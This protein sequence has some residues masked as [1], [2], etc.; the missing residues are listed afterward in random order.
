M[1]IW[2][3]N[4]LILKF[5]VTSFGIAVSLYTSFSE[6]GYFKHILNI[7]AFFFCFLLSCVFFLSFFILFITESFYNLMES[8][9]TLARLLLQLLLSLRQPG[10]CVSTAGLPSLSADF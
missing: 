7:A 2:E 6:I 9:P 10:C 4:P 3:N 1:L 5:L 8:D